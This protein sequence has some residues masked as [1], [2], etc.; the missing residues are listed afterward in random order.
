MRGAWTVTLVGGVVN[1]LLTALKFVAG[2]L[3]HSQALVADAV[4]SLSDL[5]TDGVV[6]LGLWRGQSPPDDQHHF[7]H[8]RIE[9]MATAIVGLALIA[10]AV[11]L[12][13]DSARA[14]YLHTEYH[15]TGIAIAGAAMSIAI[16]EILFH[17]TRRVGKR[18]KSQLVVANAWHHRS[19]ALSSVAVLIGVTCARLRPQWHILDAY[20]ALLVSFF[21]VKVGLDILAGAL[22][23]LSDA[24]P[25][26]ETLKRI[27][28]CARTVEGVIDAHD[29][30]VRT[31]G[32]R[33][34][35]E[36]HIV[37]D[38]RW[39]VARGHHVAKAVER[40][41]TAAVEEVDS[42]IVHVDPSPPAAALDA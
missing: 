19:D 25:D 26:P 6:L 39:S 5:F 11:Y 3:G 32:G 31:S 7:G 21:I 27:R 12:G 18:L 29:L 33:C 42:I 36:I 8:G 35:M 28:Q 20:A 37:V 23:E 4:H 10:T 2:V 38:G 16:K 24:A 30:K 34:Q 22:R 17:Y 40:E 13:V 9:T 1:V 41:L 14:I 15:P